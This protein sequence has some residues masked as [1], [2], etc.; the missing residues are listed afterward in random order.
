MSYSLSAYSSVSFTD[1][2]AVSTSISFSANSSLTFTDAYS[3]S[4]SI[5]FSA[6]SS[7]T[8]TDTYRLSTSYSLS[9][10]SSISFTDTYELKTAPLMFTIT[11]LEAPDTVIVGRPHSVGA[12][13]KNIGSETGYFKF[14]VT[15][16]KG[17]IVSTIFEPPW[18]LNPGQETCAI[19]VFVREINTTGTYTYKAVV[20][21][22]NIN[23]IDDVKEYTFKV[24][25]PPVEISS[26]IQLSDSYN[27]VTPTPAPI[28]PTSAKVFLI[29][30]G[31]LL[32]IL[33]SSR[34]KK[35]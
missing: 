1:T 28:I 14:Y 20:F 17:N 24:I 35:A 6:N 16:D 31:F 21:N 4:A 18:S 29:F 30:V 23:N 32:L 10:Y 9:A 25:I 26:N 5:S 3:L 12:C 33:L 19:S 15:D 22:K 13:V 2:Y 34:R 27:I 8:F 7:L 11:R